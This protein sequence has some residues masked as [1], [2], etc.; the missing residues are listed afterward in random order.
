[1]SYVANL[2]K[3]KALMG[4]MVGNG[5]CI[6]FVH[7]VTTIPP[8]PFWRKGPK[9]KGATLPSG[10]IIATFDV[11]GRYGNHTD[12]SSHGAVYIRQTAQG[13]IVLDQWTGHT[14][15][16]VHER[17]IRF[18]NGTGLKVDDGDQFYVVE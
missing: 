3:A 5:Q 15:Q 14:K 8:T 10:T 18:K 17:L 4:K 1:M 13:I 12:G 7:A 9:V 11:N 16:P 2:T 6:A